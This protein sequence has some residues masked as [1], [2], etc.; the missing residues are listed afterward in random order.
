MLFQAQAFG[1]PNPVG[2][3]GD[4]PPP[5]DAIMRSRPILPLFVQAQRILV[6]EDGRIATHSPDFEARVKKLSRLGAGPKS[7]Q[8]VIRAIEDYA[9]MDAGDKAIWFS[10][11]GESDPKHAEPYQKAALMQE[12]FLTHA[13]LGSGSV[14]EAHPTV[15]EHALEFSK[16]HPAEITGALV[17]SP[18]LSSD[19]KIA[20]LADLKKHDADHSSTYAAALSGQEI[21][22]G[23]HNLVLEAMVGQFYFQFRPEL[24]SEAYLALLLER[25]SF[26]KQLSDLS[27]QSDTPENRQKADAIGQKID[28][29]D[30]KIHSPCLSDFAPEHLQA[31]TLPLSHRAREVW[32]EERMRR[33][34]SLELVFRARRAEAYL[35]GSRDYSKDPPAEAEKNLR[36]WLASIS[37]AA[38]YAAVHTSDEADRE[39]LLGN[40]RWARDL[41][42]ELDRNKGRP[43]PPALASDFQSYG[44]N[45]PLWSYIN[46]RNSFQKSIS[47][48]QDNA[49]WDAER[50][51]RHAL[52]ES[53][54][55][56]IL[57]NTLLAEYTLFFDRYSEL[58][59]SAVITGSAIVASVI[60][61]PLEFVVGM[62]FMIS[63]A[64]SLS[65]ALAHKEKNMPEIISSSAMIVASMAAAASGVVSETESA[66]GL[67][68]R[69]GI[70]MA[71]NLSAA[72]FSALGLENAYRIYSHSGANFRTFGE[73]AS[74]ANDITISLGVV[75]VSG[76]VRLR[77]A[78]EGARPREATVGD[79]FGSLRKLWQRLELR[80]L[81]IQSAAKFGIPPDKFETV[82]EETPSSTQKSKG[83]SVSG[84]IRPPVSPERALATEEA[85][86]PAPVEPAAPVQA[87]VPAGP[88]LG[89]PEVLN[90]FRSDYFGPMVELPDLRN[91]VLSFLEQRAASTGLP[92]PKLEEIMYIDISATHPVFT[93]WGPEGPIGVLKRSNILEGDL[94]MNRSYM[95]CGYDPRYRVFEFD[96]RQTPGESNPIG[97]SEFVRGP[98][99]AMALREGRI[100]VEK[101]WVP[102]SEEIADRLAFEYGRQAYMHQLFGIHDPHSRNFIVPADRIA[103]TR[104][105]LEGAASGPFMPLDALK[106]LVGQTPEVGAFVENHMKHVRD[107]FLAQAR[108]VINIHNSTFNPVTGTSNIFEGIDWAE[109]NLDCDKLCPHQL[110]RVPHT[111]LSAARAQITK[112]LAQSPEQA[113]DSFVNLPK[114]MGW[115]DASRFL[116]NTANLLSGD[117]S[118]TATQYQEQLARIR[119]ATRPR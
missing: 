45:G 86:A 78:D 16:K 62:G 67:I 64:I 88:A 118:Y 39:H 70:K 18:A 108:Q 23:Q 71:G 59:K 58:A 46:L 85:R 96:S 69:A 93:I 55:G 14:K 92:R 13:H 43:R 6:G 24:E 52:A 22:I 97:V 94:F 61:G 83:R 47:V 111:P 117:P 79:S 44:E 105:D 74:I 73:W 90:A 89:L 99:L 19:E 113:W 77:K 112:R 76:V 40:V 4:V 82:M 34:A 21:Y 104:I 2:L 100:L 31:L 17:N 109:I 41:I 60:G 20:W 84:E 36:V 49:Q 32:L 75:V 68:G 103:I 72:S 63:G 28:L 5:V 30:K 10:A 106:L 50:V 116:N 1:A 53:L 37:V 66:M 57:P 114:E 3:V 115:L 38:Q 102:I 25:A 56:P 48:A 101:R 33:L 95:G 8:D 98:T 26:Q 81:L 87:I 42:E 12:I 110:E 11:L 27:F 107:G 7:R 51:V 29:V 54:P 119:A 35:L 80:E 15:F 9:G 91:A 65:R